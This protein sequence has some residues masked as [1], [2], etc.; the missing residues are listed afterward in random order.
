ASGPA[1]RRAAAGPQPE[2]ARRRG[3]GPRERHAKRGRRGARRHTA[4]RRPK[5]A[6]TSAV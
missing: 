3:S 1:S 2:R 6:P 4:A 5:I